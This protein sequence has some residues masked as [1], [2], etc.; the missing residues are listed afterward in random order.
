MLDGKAIYCAAFADGL[1]P[2]PDLTVPAW[3][4]LHR[5]LPK[6]SSPEPGKYRS[7][8]TPYLRDVM[9]DLSP[10][11]G[12][13]EIVV[14]KATQLG[15]TECGNNWFGFVADASPGPMLM[16]FPTAELAKDHSKQKL[17]PT[18]QETP[19]LKGK[20]KEHRTRDSGNT[21]QTKEFP[22][23]ILF[24]SG[25][26]SSAFFRSKS[27]RYLFLDDLD[28]FEADVGGEGDPAE[29]ARRRTDTYGNRKKIFEVSTPTIKGISR[30]E[31]SFL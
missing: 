4:A 20:V 25:S 21:I 23:G 12:I 5:M 15:F 19:R 22:G 26:N 14:M 16:V 13:S 17:Q 28:G 3:C 31:R 9:K 18:I 6:K 30:I 2:D 7:S 1:R 27:I 10:S 8:R 24:L 11:S 29:L